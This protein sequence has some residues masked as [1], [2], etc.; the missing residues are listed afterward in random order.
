VFLICMGVV[1]FS[2]ALFHTEKMMCPNFSD[3]EI[4]A[5]TWS[6]S[7]RDA[8]H[9]ECM[10][11]YARGNYT[12]GVS[13]TYGLCCHNFTRSGV[14]EYTPN[15]F[16]SIFAASWWSMVTMTT[17]GFGDIYPK[18]TP[19]HCVGFA[20]MLVGMV[21]IALPVAIVGQ[22]FQDV[23]EMHDLEE[24]KMR[25]LSTTKTTG[26][27]WT[28]MPQSDIIAKL[29]S[30]Q[31][32]EKHVGEQVSTVAQLLED[33]WEHREKLQRERA[34]EL[35]KQQDIHRKLGKLLSG[36]EASLC[37]TAPVHS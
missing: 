29:R 25:A 4:A 32:K 35:T 31:T 15:D 9:L 6:L 1:L 16:P 2:S 26:D 37:V 22:K 11:S 21:L 33:V 23:Y 34:F 17:V 7:D 28:L 36:M 30:L 24:A 12:K 5:G 13:P 3:T 27:V 18:T 8:Y 19:G 14:V 20:A 10:D